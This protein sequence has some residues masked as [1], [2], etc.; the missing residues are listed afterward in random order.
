[1]NHAFHDLATYVLVHH[2]DGR[3]IS[4]GYEL[5][6]LGPERWNE[7]VSS[8]QPEVLFARRLEEAERAR[9][10]LADLVDA[11]TEAL[12]AEARI[13]VPPIVYIDEDT[14][15]LALERPESKGPVQNFNIEFVLG[16]GETAIHRP[17]SSTYKMRP[18][19]E[20][21][22]GDGR[23]RVFRVVDGESEGIDQFAFPHPRW[24]RRDV[25][26]APARSMEPHRRR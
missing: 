4:G 12:R 14:G 2:R 18:G 5:G 1:V 7:G 9:A 15:E 23:W 3:I 16:V 17:I 24:R 11:L 22:L 6:F 20:L 26:A 10:R 13:E 8:L 19:M 21:D 25:S